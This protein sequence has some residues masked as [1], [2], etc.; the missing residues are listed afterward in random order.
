M[1]KALELFQ[2]LRSKCPWAQH[3]S[4]GLVGVAYEQIAQCMCVYIFMN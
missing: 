2:L 4:E 1:A 3:P